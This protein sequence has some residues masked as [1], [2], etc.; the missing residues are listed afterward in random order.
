MNEEIKNE[1]ELS[2]AELIESYDPEKFRETIKFE[3]NNAELIIRPITA[4]ELQHIRERHMIQKW[5]SAKRKMES[6][7]SEAGETEFL[8]LVL[9]DWKNMT[10]EVVGEWLRGFKPIRKNPDGTTT[11]LTGEIPFSI[12][13]ARKLCK[14]V[15]L[16]DNIITN[17]AMGSQQM[18]EK[19]EEEQT[20]NF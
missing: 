3:G 18:V 20:R 12:K 2:D 7:L 1:V 8:T 19:A 13:M 11:Q 6:A 9:K 14:K 5:N 16:L 15:P 10:W 17:R 4:D